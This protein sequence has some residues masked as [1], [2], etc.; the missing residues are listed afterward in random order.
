[1]NEDNNIVKKSSD[2]VNKSSKHD[3]KHFEHSNGNNGN[4]RWSY[5]FDDSD[6]KKVDNSSENNAMHIDIIEGFFLISINVL[7]DLLELFDLTGFGV[8]VGMA[9]DF[10]VGPIVILWLWMRGIPLVE[11]NAIAQA[12]ELIPGLDILP[13]RTVAIILTIITV[14]HP[15]WMQKLGLGGKVVSNVI[16]LRGKV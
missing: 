10:L 9:V 15:E 8:I 16:K 3:L 1:M 5:Q 13:I 12:V 2:S 4:E 11:R 7:G 14:N 6:K